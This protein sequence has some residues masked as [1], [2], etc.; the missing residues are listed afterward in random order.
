M[1]NLTDNEIRNK[2]EDDFLKL[3]IWD[4]LMTELKTNPIN[5]ENKLIFTGGFSTYIHSNG[6]YK[7]EDIDCKIYPIKKPRNINNYNKRI[8]NSLKQYFT[9]KSTFFNLKLKQKI[10]QDI[11]FKFLVSIID[12]ETGNFIDKVNN[13]NTK[14]TIKIAVEMPNPNDTVESGVWYPTIK[15]AYCDIGF[16]NDQIDG[17]ITDE[18]GLPPLTS[19]TPWIPDVDFCGNISILPIEYDT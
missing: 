19:T 2:Y 8:V 6:K 18:V 4:I 5:K 3:C 15:K 1:E 9:A 11:D 10:G 16:W 14:F 13:S 12:I 7:T 17:A